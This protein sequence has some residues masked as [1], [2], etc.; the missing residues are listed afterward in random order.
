MKAKTYFFRLLITLL[1]FLFS[2]GVYAVWRNLQ[3]NTN[4]HQISIVDPLIELP[5]AT[6]IDDSSNKFEAACCR[7]QLTGNVTVNVKRFVSKRGNKCYRYTV[8]NNANLEVTWIDI[9]KDKPTDLNELVSLPLGW[10]EGSME[11]ERPFVELSNSRSLVEPIAT[12]E[13]NNIYISTKALRIQPG[14]TGSFDVCM[15]STWDKRYE[16]VLLPI[17][18]AD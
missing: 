5:S 7:K 15:Q 14:K 17:N 13:Q 4:I 18:Q 2:I 1:T 16:T 8:K 10:R 11:D 9:G 3:A 6:E 12:E